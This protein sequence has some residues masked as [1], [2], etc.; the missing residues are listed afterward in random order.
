MHG[1]WL[2]NGYMSRNVVWCGC[3]LTAMLSTSSCFFKKGP[4]AFNP[5]PIYAKPVP[6][7]KPTV[8]TLPGEAESGPEVMATLPETPRIP[9]L[10]APRPPTPPKKPAIAAAP[11]AV[12]TPSEPAPEPIAVPRLGQ[13]Y[14]AE[15]TREY[16][17]TLEESLDRVRRTIAVIEKKSLTP[18]QSQALEGIRTF[19]KQ[20]E[21]A[22]EQDLLTAVN[23]ARR[24]DLLARDLAGRLP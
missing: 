3:C 6:E 21:Q 11:K 22:R 12:V 20:A 24:A 5:P 8:V 15:Q 18:E 13:I 7:P 16:S 17:K 14:T 4:R 2:H 10:P 9:S 19:Q 1:R 23:L